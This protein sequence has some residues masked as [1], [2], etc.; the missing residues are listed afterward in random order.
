M[1]KEGK[2]SPK[3]APTEKEEIKKSKEFSSD[4][5]FSGLSAE[6]IKALREFALQSGVAI[7]DQADDEEEGEEGQADQTN[8]G[9]DLENTRTLLKS[10]QRHFQVQDREEIFHIDYTSKDGS[11]RVTFDAKGVKRELG[12]TLQ[13]T[14]LTM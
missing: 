11:R 4:D 6:T 5:V 8:N 13:S 9:G 14:G 2:Q 10:V 7:V 12:Q 1:K 3:K